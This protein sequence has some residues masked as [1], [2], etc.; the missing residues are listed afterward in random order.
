MRISEIN[1]AVDLINFYGDRDENK[2]GRLEA[3]EV[4]E[5]DVQ[6]YD[7]NSDGALSPWEV[8]E[9]V[10][11]SHPIPI[12]SPAEINSMHELNS[13]GDT[14][15]SITVETDTIIQGIHFK[16]GTEVVFLK[17]GQIDHCILSEDTYEEEFYGLTPGYQVWGGG[18]T[19][20]A[21]TEGHIYNI[22]YLAGTEVGFND[23]R[24]ISHGTWSPETRLV[25]RESSI[26]GIFSQP[27]ISL[28]PLSPGRGVASPHPTNEETAK[29]QGLGMQRIV[30]L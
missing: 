3:G 10:N 4:L 25:L 23:N 17:N 19:A 13:Q 16:A 12:F 21:S 11:R 22:R 20:M 30:F 27:T 29:T 14:F 7:Q 26:V 15:N 24:F 28:S 8:M 9:A 1:S 6:V 2:N 5:S 18:G